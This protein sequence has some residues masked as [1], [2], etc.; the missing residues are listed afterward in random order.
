MRD[1]GNLRAAPCAAFGLALLASGAGCARR[2]PSSAALSASATVASSAPEPAASAPVVSPI[3]QELV[4]RTLNPNHLPVYDG[5]TGSVEGTILVTGPASPDNHVEAHSCPAAIDIYGKLFREG[6]PGTPGGPRPLAD[7]IVIAVGYGGYYL[8]EKN[9]VKSINISVNC[10]YPERSIAMTYG[11]RIEVANASKYP[12][13]PMIDTDPSP[14]VMMAAPLGAGDPIRLY[15]RRPGH[16]VMGD[17][18]QTYVREDLY[19]LRHPLHAV[20]GLDGHYRIDGVPVGKMSVA[21]QHPT[22]N[23]QAQ[24]QVSI[25]AGVVQRVDLTLEYSPKAP[26]PTDKHDLILR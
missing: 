19:V 25:E 1:M 9:P 5:P 7:A 16:S 12:F 15:P 24:A 13:A 2:E 4:D 23:S 11:Q 20:S 26:Q 6:T 17:L 22:V 18:M 21:A 8:A 10:G 3:P 14:A